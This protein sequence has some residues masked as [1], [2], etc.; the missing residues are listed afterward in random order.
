MFCGVLVLGG[1]AAAYVAAN[2]AQAQVH[3][4]VA[5]FEA[6]L[7]TMRLRFRIANLIGVC[8]SLR[9]SFLLSF[10]P[11]PGWGYAPQSACR[12]ARN[13]RKP[14]RAGQSQCGRQNRVLS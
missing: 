10:I 8:T 11:T 12:R 9:H 14:A 5:H 7:A 4:G 1:V 3:P 2:L 6:L 13:P